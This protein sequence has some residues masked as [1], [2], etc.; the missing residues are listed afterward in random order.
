M[1]KL[2]FKDFDKNLIGNIVILISLVLVII[3]IF[4]ILT[5][6]VNNVNNPVEWNGYEYLLEP[7][8]Q[9]EVN[10]EDTLKITSP[11]AKHNIE[12]KLT[13][14]QTN[15]KKYLGSDLQTFADYEING[16]YK[17]VE[18]FNG[19]GAIVPSDALEL[20]QTNDGQSYYVLKENTEFVEAFGEDSTFLSSFITSR[21]R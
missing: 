7:D 1:N 17:F 19:Y 4:L 8:M 6:A 14:D 21:Q 2:N 5:S 16:N 15:F 13:K 10:K 12:L 9:V 20:K 11:Y 18:A 3:C